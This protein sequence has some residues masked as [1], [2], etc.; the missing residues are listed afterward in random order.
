MSIEKF[1]TDQYYKQA[2]LIWL[3][4]P[5]SLINYIF[6]YLRNAL[7]KSNIF[8]QRKLPVKT[9]VVGNLIVGGSGKTQLVIYLAKL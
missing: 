3:L 7:Y 8:K 9:I 6:Y 4:L 1:F 2:N 5:I